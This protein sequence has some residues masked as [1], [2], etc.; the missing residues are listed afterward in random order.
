[1]TTRRRRRE[2]DNCMFCGN[3]L[4]GKYDTS[5]KECF[6]EMIRRRDVGKCE[7]CGK[8]PI[9]DDDRCLICK[10]DDAPWVG[11]PPGVQ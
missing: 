1:M 10:I 9:W 3:P 11:Y 5:H 2:M 8:E 6:S 4:P 7:R